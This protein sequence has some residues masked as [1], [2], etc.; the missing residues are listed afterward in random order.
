M[1]YYLS[2]V[3]IFRTDGL[4]PEQIEDLDR[5][6]DRYQGLESA[7]TTDAIGDT[8]QFNSAIRHYLEGMGLDLSDPRIHFAVLAGASVMSDH[9][10]QASDLGPANVVSSFIIGA[11]VGARPLRGIE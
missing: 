11:I 2:M 1:L 3:D 8:D 6:T 7:G 5:L 10:N 9:V 4:S